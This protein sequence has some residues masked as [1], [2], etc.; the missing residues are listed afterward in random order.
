MLLSFV[1][2]PTGPHSFDIVDPSDAS[3]QIVQH[4]LAFAT[5]YL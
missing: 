1:N 4:I 2:H 5:R 3:K